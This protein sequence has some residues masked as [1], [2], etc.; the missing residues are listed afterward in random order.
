[1]E[2]Y[3]YFTYTTCSVEVNIGKRLCVSR[4]KHKAVV[5]TDLYVSKINE[6]C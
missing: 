2:L 6:L 5:L 3:G 4:L 1:M